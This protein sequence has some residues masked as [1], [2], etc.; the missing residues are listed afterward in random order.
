MV[1]RFGLDEGVFFFLFDRI[2]YNPLFDLL[3]Q[4]GVP[5]RYSTLLWKIYMGLT[6][7]FPRTFFLY[8]NERFNIERGVKQPDVISPI[9]FN[10]GLGHAMPKWKAKLFHS[11]TFDM[12]DAWICG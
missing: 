11:P 1:C 6:V 3:V 5:R 8:G 10:A 12:L 9:L 7:F 2:E 4:Q